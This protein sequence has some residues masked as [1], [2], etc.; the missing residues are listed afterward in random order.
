MALVI[1]VQ[2]YCW[3]R[4][5]FS[6]STC[7]A[8]STRTGNGVLCTHTVLFSWYLLTVFGTPDVLGLAFSSLGCGRK[9]EGGGVVLLLAA[10]C[11]SIWLH[12]V[13]RLP[14]LAP[15][16][17]SISGVLAPAGAAAY[18]TALSA[19]GVV[20]TASFALPSAAGSS[21]CSTGD[22]GDSTAMPSGVLWSGLSLQGVS[23]M[24]D[25][26]SYRSVL[27]ALALRSDMRSAWELS[28]G[29][30]ESGESPT[31]GRWGIGDGVGEGSLI[32]LTSSW[33]FC[34]ASRNTRATS[35]CFSS[36]RC[37]SR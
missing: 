24:L 1:A 21:A 28:I 27:S 12:L 30:A 10:T 14:W 16:A 35:R 17:T 29:D 25:A 8:R 4:R 33:S 22:S 37:T 34:H 3:A 9:R 13:D 11:C 18:I 6:L 32:L 2:P 15:E 20:E 5:L 7:S 26:V 36:S 31:C 19:E 23:D